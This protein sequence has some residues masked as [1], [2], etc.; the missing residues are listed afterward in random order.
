MLAP[1]CA[2]VLFDLPAKCSA[3]I[4]AVNSARFSTIFLAA[5]SARPASGVG[6]GRLSRL[7]VARAMPPGANAPHRSA[8]A[9]PSMR[10]HSTADKTRI[11]RLA[12]IVC[13]CQVKC[14]TSASPANSPP[15]ESTTDAS[16]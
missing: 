9:V 2:S 6:S 7:P 15:I 16:T 12:N 11:V 5:R 10:K 14:R 8:L 4:S 1:I 3:A 13:S